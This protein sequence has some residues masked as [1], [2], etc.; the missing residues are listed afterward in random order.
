MIDEIQMDCHECGN[1]FDL[2][3]LNKIND[4]DGTHFYCDSCYTDI[5]GDNNDFDYDDDEDDD[6]E[7]E[8]IQ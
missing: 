2:D 8:I 3:E 5:F 6:E 7:E 1:S 4:D